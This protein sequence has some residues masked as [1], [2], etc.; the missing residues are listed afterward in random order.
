MNKAVW[1]P[2]TG[3][4]N[5]ALVER[6]NIRVMISSLLFVPDGNKLPSGK[7]RIDVAITCLSFLVVFA[8]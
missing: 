1:F 4:I 3:Y 2:F 8:E 5:L 7:A 6:G